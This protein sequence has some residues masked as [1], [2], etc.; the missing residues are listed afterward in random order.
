M[1]FSVFEQLLVM[2]CISVIAFLFSKKITISHA[3]EQFTSRLLLFVVTPCL[4]LN[5]F[6]QSYDAH[7]F[8]MLVI[9]TLVC[10]AF[11]L[12][13]TVVAKIFLRN[14]NDDALFAI[15]RIAF[16]F[17]NCGYIGI[18]LVQAV[19]GDEGVF[20]VTAYIAVFNV[21]AWL[22]GARELSKEMKWQKIAF[23]PNVIAV[24]LGFALFASPF[25]LPKIFARSIN[26]VA[27]MNTPLSMIILGMIFSLFKKTDFKQ[28]YI[29]HL[30]RTIFFRLVVASVIAF[31]IIFITYKIFPNIS[32]MR[33]MLLVLYIA[34]ICPVAVITMT[35]ASIFESDAQFASLAV[36][37][38]SAL[39]VAS[40]PLFVKLAD[41]LLK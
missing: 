36:G 14:K 5:A 23:N 17:S 20:Y 12:A 15:D 39:S 10:I 24:V 13:F 18:P 26:F 3:D 1:A 35:L 31:C 41:Y 28:S 40:I 25:T 30:A 7:K 22:Y 38:S 33:T 27:S 21:Y 8:F 34:A 11:H 29:L 19:F 37:I 4:I 2:I 32:E 16:V 6:N 9:A